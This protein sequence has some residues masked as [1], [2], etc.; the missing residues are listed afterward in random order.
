MH[1][2]DFNRKL[3][4]GFERPTPKPRTVRISYWILTFVLELMVRARPA[5]LSDELTK[6]ETRPIVSFVSQ[7]GGLRDELAPVRAHHELTQLSAGRHAGTRA[8]STP[9]VRLL[10]K[11]VYVSRNNDCPSSCRSRLPP[12]PAV[13]RQP[14]PAVRH[15]SLVFTIRSDSIPISEPLVNLLIARSHT[16]GALLLA[17]AELASERAQPTN[18]SAGSTHLPSG[19]V[20]EWHNMKGLL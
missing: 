17:C 15:V 6:L 7:T 9:P 1:W 11:N 10:G 16:S 12:P 13:F 18:A 14:K 20:S 2:L 19:Q 5:Y 3:I 4:I 8:T